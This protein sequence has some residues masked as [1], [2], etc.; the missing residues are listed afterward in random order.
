MDRIRRVMHGH[1][2]ERRAERD[3]LV[4][5][6][7]KYADAAMLGRTGRMLADAG[8][9]ISPFTRRA[10]DGRLPAKDLS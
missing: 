5:R 10:L 2:A 8:I 6:E 7:Q 9:G 3:R 4:A 1:D